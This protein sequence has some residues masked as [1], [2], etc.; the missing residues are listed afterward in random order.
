MVEKG[1]GMTLT[2]MLR[3][4]TWGRVLTPD[5]FERVS[6]ESFERSVAKGA[7]VARIGEPVVHWIGVI[8]GLLKMSV[9]TADVGPA[10]RRAH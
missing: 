6:R 1:T 10:R 4:S 8:D 3:S 5:E 7:F 9:A 2:E